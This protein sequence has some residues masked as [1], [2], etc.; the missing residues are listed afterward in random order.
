M[1]ADISLIKR[2][3]SRYVSVRTIGNSCDNRKLYDVVIGNTGSGRSIIVIGALHAREYMT[4][5]LCMA[6]IED[7]LKNHNN[8]N[9]SEATAGVLNK[10]AIHYIPMAN[11]D[12]VT[13]SQFGMSGI[14]NSTLRKAL[15]KMKVR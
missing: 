12:G 2:T 1:S 9:A 15:R 7:Y 6:Q 8:K 13:I 10:I 3:Y 4:A 14:R 11:P 5:Q